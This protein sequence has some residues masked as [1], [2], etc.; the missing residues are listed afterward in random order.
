[1]LEA[2][3]ELGE[4]VTHGQLKELKEIL[5]EDLFGLL[6]AAFDAE[7]EEEAQERVAAFVDMA[8]KNPLKIF[9]S[10]RILEEQQKNLIMSF[11]EEEE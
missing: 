4:S 1:M 5:G 3:K 10:R 7:S 6:D 8:K 11:M 2:V 9:K